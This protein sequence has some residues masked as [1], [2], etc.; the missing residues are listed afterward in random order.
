MQTVNYDF[1][2]EQFM[3]LCALTMQLIL[4]YH[5]LYIYNVVYVWSTDSLH[6]ILIFLFRGVQV[7]KDLYAFSF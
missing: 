7:Y 2:G 4:V 6:I 3:R 5:F 1:S